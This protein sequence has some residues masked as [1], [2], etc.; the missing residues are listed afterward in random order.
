MSKNSNVLQLKIDNFQLWLLFKSD[1]WIY[2]FNKGP[3]K[4][5]HFLMNNN[6]IFP[7]ITQIKVLRVMI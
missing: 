5:S 4:I 1:L 2:A 7:I 6:V 3:F